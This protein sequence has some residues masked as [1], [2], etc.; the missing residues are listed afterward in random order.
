M[1]KGLIQKIIK[2][3]LQETFVNNINV[4]NIDINANIT[5]IFQNNE[6]NL[7]KIS[8]KRFKAISVKVSD[9]I[10]KDDELEFFDKTFEVNKKV[11]CNIYRKNEIGKLLKIDIIHEFSPIKSIEI[12]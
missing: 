2:E 10:K 7:E 5:I 11:K 9:I 8:E 3:I 4:G 12:I 6:L 1:N